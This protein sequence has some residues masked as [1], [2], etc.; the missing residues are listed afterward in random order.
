MSRRTKLAPK[1]NAR[2]TIK[3]K[4]GRPTKY[5]REFTDLTYRFCLLG[6][7]DEDLAQHL[8]IYEKISI[9]CIENWKKTIPKFLRAIREGR[10][11]ALGQVVKSLFH[12]AKGYKYP[13][14]RYERRA[15]KDKDDKITEYEMVLVSEVIKEVVADVAAAKFIAWNWTKILPKEKQWNDRQEIDHRSSDGTMTPAQDITMKMDPKNASDIYK[16]M[17]KDTK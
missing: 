12:K 11:E 5:R 8:S 4:G 13:E 15:I 1:K 16:Q 6:S 2:N 9:S 14:R 3:K 17:I 7:T 10:D